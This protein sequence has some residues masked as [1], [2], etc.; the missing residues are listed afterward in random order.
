MGALRRATKERLEASWEVMKA[1][2]SGVA[3]RAAAVTADPAREALAAATAA[4]REEQ[5]LRGSRIWRRKRTAS[6]RLT[7]RARTR[8]GRPRSCGRKCT[9]R[10]KSA[11]D[12]KAEA[13]MKTVELQALR[14]TGTDPDA[15]G[16]IF[17]RRRREETIEALRTRAADAEARALTS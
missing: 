4:A 13:W 11:D 6:P 10:V 7:P 5:R 16:R 8:S 3:R 12:A 14:E 1:E 9:R 15:P 2:A 17:A